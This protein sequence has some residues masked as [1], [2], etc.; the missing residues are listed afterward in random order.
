MCVQFYFVLYIKKSQ[1]ASYTRLQHMC[2]QFFAL[3]VKMPGTIVYIVSTCHDIQLYNTKERIQFCFFV[4]H[5]CIHI[6]CF[7]LFTNGDR[8]TRRAAVTCQCVV[9]QLY[10]VRSIQRI[11]HMVSEFADKNQVCSIQRIKHMFSE[12][13]NIGKLST[14]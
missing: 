14:A 5:Y 9:K 1:F 10:Q 3:Y 7:I 4:F 2:I 8:V 6:R 11:N 12:F 13:A